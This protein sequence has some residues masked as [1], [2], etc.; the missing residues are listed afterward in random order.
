MILLFVPILVD[1]P[2]AANACT[3]TSLRA[4]MI[5]DFP[6]YAPVVPR[7]TAKERGQLV[8]RVAIGWPNQPSSPYIMFP[9]EISQSLALNLGL[10][11]EQY[12]IWTEMEM[13]AFAVLLHCRKYVH[14]V[15]SLSLP[16]LMLG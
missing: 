4:L 15:H 12:N 5:V 2:S 16:V 14:S 11:D 10:N 13:A 9:L 8:V 3:N 1:I 7:V 6:Y